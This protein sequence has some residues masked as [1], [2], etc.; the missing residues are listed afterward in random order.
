MDAQARKNVRF[1]RRMY[2]ITDKLARSA[3]GLVAELREELAERHAET[4]NR[5]REVL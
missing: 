2:R 1:Y 3:T 4:A 5:W